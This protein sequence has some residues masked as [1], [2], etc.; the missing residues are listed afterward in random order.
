MFD[1]S[2]LTDFDILINVYTYNLNK[3]LRP[4]SPVPSIP[5]EQLETSV[6]NDGR[7]PNHGLT[8]SHY[9][10]SSLE[11]IIAKLRFTHNEVIWLNYSLENIKQLV[12]KF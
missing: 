11:F 8:W 1:A 3:I 2:P 12:E 4:D 6:D 9:L 5:G 7:G 10:T